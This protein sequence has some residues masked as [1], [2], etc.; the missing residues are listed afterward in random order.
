MENLNY[1]RS[2][3]KSWFLSQEELAALF[4]RVSPATLSRYELGEQTPRAEVLLGC[5]IAFG[6]PPKSLFPNL[7]QSLEDDMMRR[8]AALDKA[9]AGKE[10]ASSIIKREFLRQMVERARGNSKAA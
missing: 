4:E 2:N 3:R 5:E 10:D 8:A 1:L 7:Y 9:L 6:V